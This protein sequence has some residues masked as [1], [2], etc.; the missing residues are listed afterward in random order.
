MALKS[1]QY[2]LLIFVL[3]LLVRDSSN[4]FYKGTANR[5][6]YPNKREAAKSPREQSILDGREDIVAL[7]NKLLTIDKETN[8]FYRTFTP[9]NSYLYLAGNLQQY[10]I[11]EAVIYESSVSRELKDFYNYTVLSKKSAVV[12]EL[13]DVMP[14]SSFTRHVHA[15]LNLHYREIPYGRDTFMFD[16]RYDDIDYLRNRN[17]EFLWDIMQVKYLIIGP[18]FS[19]VLEGFAAP[20]YYKLLGNYP[21]LDLNLYEITKDKSYSKLAVLPLEDR[22]DYDEAIKQLNSKDIDIL[23]GLYSKLVFLDQGSPDFSLLKN[24]S[25][26]S[27]R[28]YEIASKKDGVLIDFESWNHNWGLKVNN[29]NG[30]L[31]KAFQMFKGIKIEPGLNKIDMTYKLKYFKE[32]FLLGIVT[33]LIYAT[34]LGICYYKE[35]MERRRLL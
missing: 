34:L 17:V 20:D 30:K 10:K 23:R 25:S 31:R 26:G 21:K 12:T 22:Q 27:K 32:L 1:I 29:E 3:V 11:H 5:Y 28:H 6:V 15:G 9:E 33:I 4:K 18:E 19:K 24:Q 35:K 13:K 8:H 2:G 7:N 16:P 14:A